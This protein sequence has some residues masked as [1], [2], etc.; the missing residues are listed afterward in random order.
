MSSNITSNTTSNMSSN[1]SSNTT[2][3]PSVCP[4]HIAIGKSCGNLL[5][6]DVGLC[7]VH[8]DELLKKCESCPVFLFE[9]N[10]V[11]GRESFDDLA[12]CILHQ[13]IGCPIF[14]CVERKVCNG[15]VTASGMCEDHDDSEP[16]NGN[17]CP[18]I[19]DDTGRMCMV[20]TTTKLFCDFHDEQANQPRAHMC[21]Q[22]HSRPHTL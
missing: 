8:F 5:Y 3:N 13:P 15:V 4:V 20:E 16:C 17:K 9:E 6:G 22:D 1:M 19:V 14:M 10:K 7:R 18:I 21:T 12:Y 11:C 2:S